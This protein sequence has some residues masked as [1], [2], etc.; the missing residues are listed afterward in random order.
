MYLE[1]LGEKHQQ[2]ERNKNNRKQ[3]VEKKVGRKKHRNINMKKCEDY[4]GMIQSQKLC[5][6]RCV[7]FWRATI[8]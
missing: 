6:S 8:C 2:R 4:K 5:R 3:E 1:Y 7:C